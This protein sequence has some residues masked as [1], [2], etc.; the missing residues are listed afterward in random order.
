MPSLKAYMEA[1]ES[2]KHRPFIEYAEL[3][4]YLRMVPEAVTEALA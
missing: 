3:L 2:V 1:L 4:T